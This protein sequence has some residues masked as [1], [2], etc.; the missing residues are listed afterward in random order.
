MKNN[1]FREEVEKDNVEQEFILREVASKPM[2][3]SEEELE[4]MSNW[5]QEMEVRMVKQ[6]MRKT[7]DTDDLSYFK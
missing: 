6:I 4:E 7:A 5:S 3:F 1:S 2:N